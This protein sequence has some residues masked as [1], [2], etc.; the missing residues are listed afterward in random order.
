MIAPGGKLRYT[1]TPNPA[2]L[3][4]YHTHTMA[5]SNLSVV[6]VDF[7]ADNPGN[8]LMHCRKQLHMDFG[9]MQLIRY[10]T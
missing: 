8:T 9:F 2:W 5:G 6:A 4:W 10:T 7:I 3:R 1:L